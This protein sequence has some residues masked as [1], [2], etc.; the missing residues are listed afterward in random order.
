MINVAIKFLQILKNTANKSHCV[1]AKG[2]QEQQGIKWADPPP[3]KKSP[4]PH[5]IIDNSNINL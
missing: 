3:Q 2:L 1:T 4:S 5:K